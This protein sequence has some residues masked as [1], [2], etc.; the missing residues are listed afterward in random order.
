MSRPSMFIGSS[1]EGKEIAQHVRAQLT[2]NAE[3]TIWNEGPFGLGQGTLESLVKALDQFDFA[4]LVLTPDD[5]VE[6]REN[7]MQSPRDNV[8]FECGLFMGRLGRE[9]TFIIYDADQPLK[10]PSDLAGLTHAKYRGERKDRN[11]LA[12]VGEACDPIRHM[13]RKHG[14]REEG[15]LSHI[16]V[17]SARLIFLLRYL[18]KMGRVVRTEFIGRVLYAYKDP[19]L[20]IKNPYDEEGWRRAASYALYYLRDLGLVEYAGSGYGVKISERGQRYLKLPKIQEDYKHA[21]S[22]SLSAL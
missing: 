14:S 15:T 20:P 7:M 2:D 10:I 16:A 6:S 3:V 9:R 12:A 11:L 17:G 21:F 8:L 18:D 5:M 13:V 4:V 1:S 22:A 19:Q